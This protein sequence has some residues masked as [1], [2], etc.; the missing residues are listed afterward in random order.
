MLEIFAHTEDNYSAEL[1]VVTVHPV[2]R[3]PAEILRVVLDF[4]EHAR[5]FITSEVAL[6]LL[7]LLV[8]RHDLVEQF[9]M[10]GWGSGAGNDSEALIQLLECCV[11]LKVRLTNS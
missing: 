9:E 4:G 10:K 7:K 6:H 8:N 1:P 3:T 2:L 11:E 5:E